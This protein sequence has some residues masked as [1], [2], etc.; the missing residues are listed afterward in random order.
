MGSSFVEF[1]GEG[2]WAKD[3][4]LVE[5]GQ[6]IEKIG[7]PAWFSDE[8]KKYYHG[9]SKDQVGVGC[10]TL[11]LD[12]LLKNAEQLDWY[13]SVIKT[14]E[15]PSLNEKYFREKLLSLL[16]GSLKGAADSGDYYWAN[17]NA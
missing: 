5:L 10:L 1:K 12:E 17:K 2:F 14:V 13:K 3:F 11:W 9:L 15:L 16:N 4:H 8:T 6:E 7:I